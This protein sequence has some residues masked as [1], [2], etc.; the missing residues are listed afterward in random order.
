MKIKSKEKNAIAQWLFIKSRNVE[1]ITETPY[2]YYSYIILEIYRH[3][4]YFL[5]I[6]CRQAQSSLGLDIMD[7]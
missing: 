6:L 5:E 3:Q 1:A 2:F 7:M 4:L